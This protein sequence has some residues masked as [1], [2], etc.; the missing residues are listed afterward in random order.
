M[1]RNLNVSTNGRRVCG[2]PAVGILSSAIPTGFT[3][4]ALLADVIDSGF[5]NR[6]YHLR[7]K[8]VAAN[9]NLYTYE[10]SSAVATA[11]DGT[12]ISTREVKK[13]DQGVGLVSTAEG[14]VNMTFGAATPTVSGVTVSPATATGST[15]FT[16]TVAGA[17]SPS[18]TVTWSRSGNAGS[19]NATTGVFTAPAQTSSV[20]VI[21]ITAL[22]SQD[23]TT[24]GTATVTIAAAVVTPPASTVSGVTVTPSSG[25][26]A[27]GAT[28]AHSATVQ[29][30][31]SPSQAVTWSTNLGTINASTGLLTAPAATNVMQTGT[32]TARSTQDNNYAG[33]ATFTVAAIV[34]VTPPDP[35]VTVTEVIVSPAGG[36]MAGAATRQYT[37]TVA[38]AN[39]PGQGVTWT[40]S[41]GSIDSAGLYT[42]PA[43]IHPVQFATITARSS[44]NSTFTGSTVVQINGSGIPVTVAPNRVLRTSAGNR[45]LRG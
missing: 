36:S 30:A 1:R 23:G 16:A 18:Q 6:L 3:N 24:I 44:V 25:A 2:N 40:A 28:R 7:M 35:T 4:A 12:Y 9:L 21:T 22:S 29:G 39:S 17:N 32:V 10:D 37:A 34:V 13:Y 5:P 8:V 41:I 45:I 42:A 26:I 15:T 14:P 19:I 38:G 33:T 27:A 31:N 11:P 43:A 20:Q